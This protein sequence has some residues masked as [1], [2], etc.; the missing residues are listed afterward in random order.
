MPINDEYR[1][2]V[3]FIKLNL[4]LKRIPSIIFKLKELGYFS[5]RKSNL[6][7]N[8]LLKVNK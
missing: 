5:E 2:I 3:L 7:V 8:E 4:A 1:N 6:E